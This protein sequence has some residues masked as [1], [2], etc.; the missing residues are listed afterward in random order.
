MLF[1][2]GLR[3]WFGI[4]G[5]GYSYGIKRRFVIEL[6]DLLLILLDLALKLILFYLNS[7]FELNFAGC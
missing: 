5:N 6:F 3:K 1:L 2:E 4:R 7:N